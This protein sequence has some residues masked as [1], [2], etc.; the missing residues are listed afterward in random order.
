MGILLLPLSFILFYI[1]NMSINVSDPAVSD[2]YEEIRDDKSQTNWVFFGFA[3]SKPDRLV[4][5]GTGSGGLSEFVGQL[6]DDVAG[7][8]YVRMNMSNDE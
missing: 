3:D 4:V 6:S 1:S 5:A 8:G 2:A 7:W